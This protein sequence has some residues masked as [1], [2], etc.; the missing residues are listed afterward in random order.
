MASRNTS[1]LDEAMEGSTSGSEMPNE[2]RQAGAPDIWAA[3]SY[4]GSMFSRA[5]VTEKKMIGKKLRVS[6]STRPGME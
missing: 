5:A 2:A 6:T 4:I 3:S 1:T